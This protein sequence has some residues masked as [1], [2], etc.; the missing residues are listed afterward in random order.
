MPTSDPLAE[1]TWP[2]PCDELL[3]ARIL[4]REPEAI[5]AAL[6]LMERHDPKSL[7]EALWLV[8]EGRSITAPVFEVV[9]EAWDRYFH[10]RTMPW[11]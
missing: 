2:A 7:R 9:A 11:D 3:Q 8:D 1:T 10:I 5:E 6:W 4:N